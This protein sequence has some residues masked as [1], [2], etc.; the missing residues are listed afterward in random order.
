[1]ERR[2]LVV[3][4]AVAV[5]VVAVGLSTAATMTRSDATKPATETKRVNPVKKAKPAAKP[6]PAR[7]P[8]RRTDTEAPAVVSSGQAQSSEEAREYWTE[9]RMQDAQPMEKTRPST[10]GA[11]PSA[12]SPAPTGVS[13]PGET[14]SK[15]APTPKPATKRKHSD[16]SPDVSISPAVLTPNYWTDER[17]ADA[18]P[19]DNTRPGGT[20]SQGDPAPGGTSVPGSPPP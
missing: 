12:Q 20:G 9:E 16:A 8:A 14:P 3:L 4:A 2:L 1:M 18:Q 19:L 13:V 15:V 11:R 6:K 7:A 10:T 5:G 17:M